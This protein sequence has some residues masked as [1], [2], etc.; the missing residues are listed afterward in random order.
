MIKNSYSFRLFYR[1]VPWKQ[2]QKN[3]F[4][5]PLVYLSHD[6]QQLFIHSDPLLSYETRYQI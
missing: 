5:N 3:K 1:V 2:N 6:I 4:K